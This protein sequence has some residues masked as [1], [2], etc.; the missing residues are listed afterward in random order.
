MLKKILSQEI[1]AACK[2]C[3]NYSLES[4]WD[5]PGFTLKEYEN[6]IVRYPELVSRSYCRN[7]LYYFKTFQT[8]NN[9]HLCPFLGNNGCILGEEKPFKCAIWPLYVVY[10][11]NVIYLAISNVCPNTNEI[12][13]KILQNEFSPSIQKINQI[14]K[15]YPE[16]IENNRV[17]F[18]LLMQLDL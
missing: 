6:V 9:K 15:I 17:H 1:C 8:D 14:I 4:L 7:N 2:I 16:L 13:I 18:K 5:I 10:H 11:E 12:A 3:C